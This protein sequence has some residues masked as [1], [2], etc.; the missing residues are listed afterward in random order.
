MAGVRIRLPP[1]I[2]NVLGAE[3]NSWLE[4]EREIG[5]ETTVLELLSSLVVTFP[6]FRESVFN[7]DVGLVNEQMNVVLNDELL[8]FAEIS[9]TKLAVND[10]VTLLPIYSGG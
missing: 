3:G 9:E 10:M 2:A 1:H 5:P 7:P 4:V 6:G 8:T